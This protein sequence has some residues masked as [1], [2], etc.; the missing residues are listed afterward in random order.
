MCMLLLL[1][2]LTRQACY[3]RDEVSMVLV[4][5]CVARTPQIGL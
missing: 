1:Y 4:V 2:L 3:R 5:G